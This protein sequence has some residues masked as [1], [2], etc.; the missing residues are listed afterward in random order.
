M[1]WHGTVCPVVWEVKAMK[2]QILPSHPHL[3]CSPASRAEL[4]HQPDFSQQGPEERKKKKKIIPELERFI[5]IFHTHMWGP[6]ISVTVQGCILEVPFKA[7]LFLLVPSWIPSFQKNQG[8]FCLVGFFNLLLP[9]RSIP[10]VISSPFRKA[11]FQ[12]VLLVANT[13]LPN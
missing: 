1:A 9:L 3:P 2:D 13:L 5:Y 11:V 7:H 4:P 6:T 12:K 8:F 10:Q